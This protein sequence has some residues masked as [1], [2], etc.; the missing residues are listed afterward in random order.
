M[1][2]SCPHCQPGT[3]GAATGQRLVALAQ[4]A[5][6]RIDQAISA[7][8]SHLVFI[9]GQGHHSKDHVT[10]IK[11]AVEQLAA[12]RGLP[13]TPNKPRVGCL[14]LQLPQPSTGGSLMALLRRLISCL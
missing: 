2:A 12:Q 14:W 7:K 6:E 4:V 11:P 1:W 3:R 13:C 5:N 9:V 8:R 10:H